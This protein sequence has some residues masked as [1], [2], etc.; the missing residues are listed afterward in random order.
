VTTRA[1]EPR[2]GGRAAALALAI[3]VAIALGAPTPAR[4]NSWG[5]DPSG[6]YLPVGLSTALSVG[7]GR[8]PG[9][10]IG[11]ELSFA[12]LTRAGFWLGLYTD[13]L[14]DVHAEALRWGI[15]PE[16]GWAFIGL[17][18]G[19]VN[20][21]RGDVHSTGGQA[22][23]VATVGFV[24][25]YARWDLLFEPTVQH[26]G[27]FGLLLKIPFPLGGGSSRHD[28]DDDPPPAWDGPVSPPGLEPPPPTVTPGRDGR[29][30]G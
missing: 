3:A 19:V 23:L 20:E 8:G 13:V 26:I 6:F 28:D 2:S 21:W 10:V 22:R 25:L 5:L 4:A 14:W 16:L 7:G 18:A 9:Y 11:G 24:A 27:E 30:D 12:R 29:N 1:L 17:D 15:G